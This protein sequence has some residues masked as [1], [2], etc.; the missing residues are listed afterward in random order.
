L[1]VPA[2]EVLTMFETTQSACHSFTTKC[3]TA[4]T[5]DA[6]GRS[7]RW[8]T[9]QRLNERAY[10]RA[11]IA[12][13]PRFVANGRSVRALRTSRVQYRVEEQAAFR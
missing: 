9:S 2:R 13:R 5:R 8:E 4:N 11:D 1:R 3:A 7:T 12:V 10:A 6:P